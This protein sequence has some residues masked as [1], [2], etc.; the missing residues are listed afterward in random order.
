MAD[1]ANL[2]NVNKGNTVVMNDEEWQYASFQVRT[3]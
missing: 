1:K 3:L 2:Q